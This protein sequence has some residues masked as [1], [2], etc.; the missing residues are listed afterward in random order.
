MRTVLL[1]GATGL[2]GRNLLP[3]LLEDESVARV[4]A[5]VRRPTGI[6]N[7]KL[8]E[9]PF[10]LANMPN[11]DQIFCALGTTMKVAGSKEAF[12]K[13][14][15]DYPLEAARIGLARGATHYLLVSS[16]GANAKSRIFYTRVKG[17]V[18]NALIA[19]GY[20]SVTILR[21]SFLTGDR[22]E[23]RLGEKIVTR[24]GWLL[25]RRAKPIAA[26]TVARAAVAL[27]RERRPGV[28]ILESTEITDAARSMAP[29]GSR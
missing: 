17:E 4:V 19:L 9:R 29:R 7:A 22:D 27:A 21:P 10:D 6:T 1:L 18:E 23:Y 5:M 15:Y 11:V 8:E 28:Q 14:D 24:L 2:V 13:V 26:A 20:P 3:L 25:P 12:R 16:Q